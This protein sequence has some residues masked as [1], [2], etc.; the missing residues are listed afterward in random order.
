MAGLA[1]Q[2]AMFGATG[3]APSPVVRAVGGMFD[4]SD[5]KKKSAMSGLLNF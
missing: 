1:H 3:T 5:S 4:K 2:S